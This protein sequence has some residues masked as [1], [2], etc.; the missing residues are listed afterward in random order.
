[1]RVAAAAHLKHGLLVV[2]LSL[3]LLSNAGC[4]KIKPVITVIP[5][6]TGVLLWDPL[7]EG[8]KDT[9]QGTGLKMHWEAPSEDDIDSQLSLVEA[10]SAQPGGGIIFVPDETLASRSVVMEAVRRRVPVVVVDDD[11]GPSPGPFLSYVSSDEAA[12]TR[13]AAQQLARQLHGR[14]SVAIVGISPQQEGSISREVLLERAITQIAPRIHFVLRQWGDPVITHE[15]QICQQLLRSPTPPDAILALSAIATRGAYYAKIAENRPPKTTIIGFDQDDRDLV[16]PIRTGEIDAVVIQDTR[17]IGERAARNIVA[18]LSGERA[19]AQTLVP[20]L[21]VTRDTLG[22][23]PIGALMGVGYGGAPDAI[24]KDPSSNARTLDQRV[25]A[26]FREEAKAHELQPGV[27]PIGSFIRQPGLHLGITVQGTVIS[28]LPMLE[29]QDDTSAVFISSFASNQKLKLGD[30]VAVHGDLTSER[31]RSRIE[32]AHIKVLW[33]GRPLAPLAVTAK[34]LTAGYRGQSIE[35]EG[36]VLSRGTV[37]GTPELILRDGRQIFPALLY[38]TAGVGTRQPDPGSR[39]KLR[40]TASALPQLT[41]GVYPFAVLARQ[42]E[43]LSPPPWWS[44]MHIVILALAAAFVL[45]LLQW[46]LHRG[47]RWHMRSV[48]REREQLAFEMHDTLA[49]SFTGIAYQLHAARA[50]RHGEQAVQGHI[51][52]A[53]QMVTLS[54]REASRTIASLRPQQRDAPGILNALKQ[55][56]ERLSAAGDLTIRT[57]LR[58]RSTQLPLEV[59]EAFFRIGQEAISNAIQHGRCGNLQI[60]LQVSKRLASLAVRD[61]GVGFTPASV[62]AGLGITGMKKRAENIRARLSILSTQGNGS[63]VMVIYP[64]LF[65]SGLFYK[66]R[67]KLIANLLSRSAA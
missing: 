26:A 31:F 19:P 64:L 38:S 53:L 56:A 15:Q 47:Q 39:V 43:I 65:T 62:I 60:E 49:Q 11:L 66:L 48:L 8:A 10:A 30:V 20:P 14:G 36:T 61:D 34:Q 23:A 1:M 22:Q 52:H 24:R 37:D 35:V 5:R 44:P 13:R 3:F 21:L 59:T 17:A 18:Q 32:N 55:S 46:L 67:A 16:L 41:D 58:G 42:L 9:L 29:V 28:A 7:K 57:S 6:S 12:G 27:E 45:L 33:S 51:E 50:E 54:H 40:G 63:T 25:L 2:L 4:G